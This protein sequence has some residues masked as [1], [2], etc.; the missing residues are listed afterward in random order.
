MI[1]IILAGGLNT[2]MKMKYPTPLFK[3]R[4]IPMIVR[5]INNAILLKSQYIFVILNDKTKDQIINNVKKYITN[6]NIIYIVQNKP[7]G[8]ADALKYCIPFLNQ[9][10]PFEKVLILTAIQ[11]LMSFYTLNTFIKWKNKGESKILCCPVKD[12]EGYHR[13]KRDKKYNFSHLEL[14]NKNNIH[15]N[16]ISAEVY[17]LSI[18]QIIENINKVKE[19]KYGEYD[20][21]DLINILKPDIYM[22]ESKFQKEL[23]KVN[24]QIT[25]KKIK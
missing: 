3:I 10:E 8:T 2:R 13:I 19:N 12:P 16:Y 14:E 15:Y 22:L 17:A 23:I 7:K 9:V 1:T 4:N 24:D 5:T 25:L 21:I 6:K 18:Y 20:I 11:P